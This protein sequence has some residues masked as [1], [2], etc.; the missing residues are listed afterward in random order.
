MGLAC[1]HAQGPC[2]APHHPI[3]DPALHQAPPPPLLFRKHALLRP[4]PAPTPMLQETKVLV[5]TLVRQSVS[6]SPFGRCFLVLSCMVHPL[7]LPVTSLITFCFMYNTRN[8]VQDSAHIVLNF[9]SSIEHD[10]VGIMVVPLLL[11]M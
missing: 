1:N 6:L 11:G 8:S 3:F 7:F 10:Y 4:R 5:G 2:N 9:F